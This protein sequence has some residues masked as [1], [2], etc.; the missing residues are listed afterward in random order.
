ML[1]DHGRALRQ[2]LALVHRLD[3]RSSGFTLSSERGHGKGLEMERLW[4][5]VAT[6]PGRDKPPARNHL[7]SSN[8]TAKGS[9]GAGGGDGHVT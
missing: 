6:Q 1:N 7:K 9:A 8:L 2:F 5:K 4:N 3:R